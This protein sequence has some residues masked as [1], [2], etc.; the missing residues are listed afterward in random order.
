MPE[1]ANQKVVRPYVDRVQSRERP[2]TLRNFDDIAHVW[3]FEFESQA[4]SVGLSG[5]SDLCVFS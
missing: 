1:T 2:R 3:L 4:G 5:V